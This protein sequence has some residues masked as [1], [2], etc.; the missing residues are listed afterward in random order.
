MVSWGCLSCH[1]RKIP[2][3]SIFFF[4]CPVNSIT[5]QHTHPFNPKSNLLYIVN[6]PFSY[7]CVKCVFGISETLHLTQTASPLN[8]KSLFLSE[9][10]RGSE[11]EWIRQPLGFKIIFQNK[12]LK[13][14]QHG[15]AKSNSFYG[16]P[17]DKTDIACPASPEKM[18]VLSGLALAAQ[19]R[20]ALWLTG[21][22]CR[23]SPGDF[24][25]FFWATWVL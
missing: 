12:P 21:S 18:F 6:W 16:Q 10:A 24:E 13:Q 17:L 22:I 20:D 7:Q 3:D 1:K 14:L 9:W 23:S 2:L 5:N 25:K 8:S 11:T 19:Q 15:L 4:F